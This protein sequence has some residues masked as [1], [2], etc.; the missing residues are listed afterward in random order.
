MKLDMQL[1]QVIL[2]QNMEGLEEDLSL[3]LSILQMLRTFGSFL[4]QKELSLI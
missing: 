3:L 2:V 1:Q 4:K